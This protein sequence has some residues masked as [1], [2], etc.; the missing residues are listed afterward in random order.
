MKKGKKKNN[1][2]RPKVT[3]LPVTESNAERQATISACLI[4]KNEEYFLPRCLRSI[5]DMVDE[6][7]LV[8]TGSDDRT[9][10]IAS[11]FDCKIYHFPW[12]GDFSAARNHSLKQATK[13]WIFII[14]ADEEVPSGDAPQYQQLVNREDLKMISLSVYNQS[15]ESGELSSVATSVRLFRRELNLGYM[16][17]VHNRLITPPD[18][19]KVQSK[20]RLYHYGYDLPREIQDKKL[21]RTRMLLEKQLA[22]NADDLFANFNMIQVLRSHQQSYRPE[23]SQKIIE[24]ADRVID[25]PESKLDMYFGHHLMTLYQKAAALATL[26]RYDEAEDCCRKA[27]KIRP[28]YLDVLLT[29]GHIYNNTNRPAQAREYY[30]LY[31]DYQQKY[32]PDREKRAIVIHHLKNRHHAWYGLADLADREKNGEEALRCFNHALETREPYLDTYCRLGKLYLDKG[33]LE[34]AEEVFLKEKNCQES[35]AT[36]SFGLGSVRERLG[37]IVEAVRYYREAVELAPDNALMRHHLGKVLLSSE[38]SENGKNE[39]MAALDSLP[40]N[41]ILAYDAANHLFEAGEIDTAA[42]LYERVLTLQPDN[43][44]ALNN[45]GNCLFKNGN[46]EQACSKYEQLIK[47]QPNYH[48]AYR[49][50]GLAHL[51]LGRLESALLV[52]TEYIGFCPEDT[53]VLRVLGDLDYQDGRFEEAITRYENYLQHHPEDSEVILCLSEAYRRL[54][55]IDSARLGYRQV[56]ARIPDQQVA[57]RRLLETDCPEGVS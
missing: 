56:L 8:D 57:A 48:S 5:R 10:E 54:G 1:A 46:Y 47:T 21:E 22:D 44:D 35:S 13:D 39:I 50:L 42:E 14:D 41:P 25:S 52:L 49:N 11:E 6:I 27:L 18:I 24:Y 38:R 30:H 34:T 31:L 29:L 23:I 40:A 26:K 9:V 15:P 16:G 45:L 33:D 19:T 3:P 37:D 43:A 4:V 32:N 20:L 12:T 2:G 28:D 36:A 51:R 53:G 55:F 17:I 7:I